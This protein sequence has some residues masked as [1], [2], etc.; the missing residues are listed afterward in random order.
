MARRKNSDGA[1]YLVVI[2]L[3]VYGIYLFIKYIVLPILGILLVV[4]LILSLGYALY[5]S[6]R[7][8]I[9]SFI[10]HI[11]PYKTYIDKS[12]NATI[13]IKR[14][15][16]FGPGYHQIRITV[17]E[18]FTL[19]TNYFSTLGTW[20]DHQLRRSRWFYNMWIWIFYCA[21]ILCASVLG[22][23]WLVLFSVVLSSV[24]FTGMC[25]FYVL[26]ISLWIADRFLLMLRSIQSRCPQ[27]KRISVVP[28]FICPNCG[29]EHKNLTPGPYGILKRKCA[30]GENLSTTYFNGRSK[31]TAVCPFCLSGLAASDAQ[32]FGIQ[33]VG[34]V[35]AGKTT[36]L[37]AF[38][39]EYLEVLKPKRGVSLSKSPENA[40]LE[41]EDWFQRGVSVSTTETNANMYSLIHKI[42]DSTPIQMTIYDIAG[43]AFS[44]LGNDIQQQQFQYCE[45]I[46]FVVDPIANP[47]DAANTASSFI[48][49]F[50]NLKGKHSV[51][52]SEV[53][54]AVIISKSD[55][56]KKE[57]G[58]PKIK[59]VLNSDPQK[60]SDAGGNISLELTRNGICRDF[61]KNNGFIN[62]LNLIE[63]EFN[64]VK[65]YPVSAMGHEA[66]I[67][68]RYEPWGVL[69]PINWLL[70]QQGAKFQKIQSLL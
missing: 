12:P 41:L 49:E 15:Y 70:Q 39:H 26:F 51:K 29:L 1:V 33:L 30:C 7:S 17:Q 18:A 64:N 36:F 38:W 62:I 42:D 6:L 56:Y 11:N 19:Q 65:Y 46:V 14:N 48:H 58:F 37:A 21:A 4:T 27:C 66:A 68:E 60:Y 35:S 13:G 20:K 9:R 25:I 32:Q 57:V 54:V 28:I 10:N 59:A 55:L 5:T 34:G 50:S 8:F 22:F 45:G 2:G 3:I 69:E 52:I 40:F 24:L 63:A 44:S 23:L 47:T 16:F 53:P 31:Y 61:L 67:G 43:E